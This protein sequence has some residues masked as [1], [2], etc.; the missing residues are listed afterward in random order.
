MQVHLNISN[1][2]VCVCVIS[3][4]CKLQPGSCLSVFSFSMSTPEKM[5][6]ASLLNELRYVSH[7]SNQNLDSFLYLV[8]YFAFLFYF[9]PI[10][11]QP[12][13]TFKGFWKVFLKTKFLMVECYL[14]E[15]KAVLE[16]L[17]VLQSLRSF[18]FV[19]LQSISRNGILG[20]R[21]WI[22]LRLLYI[23]AK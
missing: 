11:C 4:D 22:F 16:I 21:A 13:L 18:S 15:W 14:V 8:L 1:I 9:F 10:Q 19:S 5:L 7:L 12:F 23:F 20:E 17:F 2:L 6:N 3:L